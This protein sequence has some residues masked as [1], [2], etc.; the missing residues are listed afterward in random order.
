MLKNFE[1]LALYKVYNELKLKIPRYNN[2]TYYVPSLWTP[3]NEEPI[4]INSLYKVNPAQFLV[5]H[6]EAIFKYSQENINTYVNPKLS[7]NKHL[8]SGSKGNWIV[9][10]K[11]Y[12]VF[13]RLSTAFDH[14]NNGQLD[15][16]T[17]L[18]ETGTFLKTIALLGHIKR[19][20]C[21]VLH[22]L[23]ITLIGQYGNK[24]L[25]GS[26]YAIKNPYKLEPSLADPISSLSVDEQ[27]MALV[28]AC[29]LLNIRVVL[30]F[31]FRTASRDSDWALENP[32]WFYWIAE[33][34][35][36]R[37][38]GILD[39][40]KSKKAY[41]NPIF[42]ENE[43]AIIKAKVAANDFSNL[44]PPPIEYR[45][46]FY[47]PPPKEKV[48][49]DEKGRI[50][51]WSKDIETGQ[52]VLV[53][54][55]GAFADWP[56]DDNQPPWTDVTYLRM[57]LDPKDSPNKFNYIAY[58][59]VR[60]YD[61]ELANP[62]NIN[63]GLWNKISDIIPYYQDKFGIDGVM[64]DMGHAVPISLMQEIITKA[65]QKDPDFCFLSENFEIKEDS[66]KAGYNA[67]VGYAW[68]VEY[69]RE[70][71]R[72][73]LEHVGN[74]GVP[75]A[76]FGAVENHN[77]PRAAARAGGENYSIYAFMVNCF[78]P[79]SIPFIH[80]G[81]ELGDTYPVNTGLDFT[82]ED[83]AKFRNKPLPLF[84]PWVLNWKPSSKILNSII[85]II[86]LRDKFLSVLN[87]LENNNFVLLETGNP[88]VF[89]FIRQNND[90][91]LLIVFNRNL[92]LELDVKL[93][94]SDFINT[95]NLNKNGLIY[96]PNLFKTSNSISGIYIQNGIATFSLKS[97]E[98]ALFAWNKRNGAYNID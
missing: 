56:P 78:L 35:P 83:L 50:L 77:T 36:D 84:D 62:S 57:Y 39:S 2:A 65:R 11:I 12:N 14:N 27:F 68:W 55:P 79:R 31:V 41:G 67:V 58:N 98:I 60:M 21:D 44:P 34:I 94:L 95:A 89:A 3:V 40:D 13:V 97:C 46:F 66:V 19:L 24:G 15:I 92:E 82:N 80:S 81:F 45:K 75:I 47:P 38:I 23:P 17:D 6:I 22:L 25:L 37:E 30:E 20:G 73:L 71:M 43:L 7:L 96:L 1:D 93:S 63:R 91:K 33:N 87:N 72:D 29:H 76:Y 16:N 9:K 28:E 10:S 52:E 32:A 26:P 61:N 48:F 70:G 4:S 85:K 86:K 5:S 42:T 74:K 53:K 49:V 18:K 59:T 51:G 69:K 90:D 64:V 88:D 8:S 54:I